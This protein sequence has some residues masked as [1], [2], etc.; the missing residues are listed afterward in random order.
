M[1]GKEAFTKLEAGYTL[2]RKAWA[3]N[4]KCKAYFS[5]NNKSIPEYVPEDPEFVNYISLFDAL[6]SGE[7]F[8][9]DWEILDEVL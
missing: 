2:R 4:I 9:D 1:T 6:D 5:D 3:P 7:F 8:E